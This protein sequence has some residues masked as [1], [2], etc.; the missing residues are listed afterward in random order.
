M[1]ININKKYRSSTGEEVR[2]Y[3]VDA[4]GEF[5]V[6]GAVRET[7]NAWFPRTWTADGRTSLN[8]EHLVEVIP[9]RW[10]AIVKT[11]SGM[12]YMPRDA[13]ESREQTLAAKLYYDNQERIPVEVIDAWKQP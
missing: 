11:E 3:S 10:R 2:I 7:K 1:K 12:F 5:P 9:E 6:H 13:F 8:L 4:G